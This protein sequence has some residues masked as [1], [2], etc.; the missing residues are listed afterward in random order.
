MASDPVGYGAN[1]EGGNHAIQRIAERR[2]QRRK[3]SVK[4]ALGQG[5]LYAQD[6]HGPHRCSQHE[7][8][9]DPVDEDVVSHVRLLAFGFPGAPS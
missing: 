9:D 7:A 1:A 6:A 5:S 4:A 8:E 2:T 3:Q